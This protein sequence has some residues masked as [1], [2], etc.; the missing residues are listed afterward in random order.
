[1]NN[2]LSNRD[3]HDKKSLYWTKYYPADYR[4]FVF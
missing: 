4:T 1:M 2:I 3:F